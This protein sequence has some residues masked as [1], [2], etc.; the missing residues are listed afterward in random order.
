LSKGSTASEGFSGSG[1]VHPK[2]V[3]LGFIDFLRG[4]NTERLF[5]DVPLNK[6][7]YAGPSLGKRWAR[8][9]KRLNAD[10]PRTG[11]HSLRHNWADACRAAKAHPG[12]WQ[13]AGGWSAGGGTSGRYG[14]G[15]DVAT[16]KEELE[17][18]EPL[19]VGIL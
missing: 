18:I 16:V 13:Q 7:G 19:P 14:S 17:R 1:K 2:L 8:L 12:I 9:V 4:V 5:A 6:H 10:E 11:Y 15:Y 3:E